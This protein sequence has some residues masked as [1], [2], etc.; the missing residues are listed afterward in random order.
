MVSHRWI[1]I[2]IRIDDTVVLFRKS[3]RLLYPSTRI[4]WL[5]L[6]GSSKKR[7]KTISYHAAMFELAQGPYTS[8][9]KSLINWILAMLVLLLI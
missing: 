1:F 8:R 6:R 5:G 7:S 4:G 2:L 9:P 3:L